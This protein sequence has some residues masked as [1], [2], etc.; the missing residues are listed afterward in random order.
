MYCREMYKQSAQYWV[1]GWKKRE[2]LVNISIKQYKA[3]YT[4]IDIN[5]HLYSPKYAFPTK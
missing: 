2:N 3:F 4:V 5:I 1:N